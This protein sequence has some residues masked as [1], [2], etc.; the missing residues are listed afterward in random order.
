M[1]SKKPRQLHAWLLYRHHVLAGFCDSHGGD[2]GRVRRHCDMANEE[3]YRIGRD[4]VVQE[5]LEQT[6]VG[7]AARL[8]QSAASTAFDSSLNESCL[9]GPM[10]RGGYQQ[11]QRETLS[12]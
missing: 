11:G 2:P 5:L 1:S 12:N 7:A 10:C 8:A 9:A 4:R 3:K 6:Q